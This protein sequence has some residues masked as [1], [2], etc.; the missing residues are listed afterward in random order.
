MSIW[1]SLEWLQ[2]NPAM[3]AHQCKVQESSGF[4][5]VDLLLRAKASRPR[6]GFLLEC[7]L[8][9]LPGDS[10]STLQKMGIKV[11]LPISRFRVEVDLPQQMI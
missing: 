5:G 2:A 4:E 11:Y 10:V 6:E 1:N 3:S 9:G 7:P 8:C